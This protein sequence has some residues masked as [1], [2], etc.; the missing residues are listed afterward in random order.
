[1]KSDFIRRMIALLNEMWDVGVENDGVASQTQSSEWW[2]QGMS[3]CECSPK[4][5]NEPEGNTQKRRQ[6]LTSTHP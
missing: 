2:E 1:M 5:E 6:I 4:L 3:I